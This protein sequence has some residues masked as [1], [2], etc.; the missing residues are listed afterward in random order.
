MLDRIDMFNQLCVVSKREAPVRVIQLSAYL[1]RQKKLFL[2]V[3]RGFL[4]T[5]KFDTMD[6]ITQIH[7]I[8]L[9]GSL[10]KSVKV[11]IQS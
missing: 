6:N 7:Q 10:Q 2:C 1:F 4:Q 8:P 3:I 11:G 9:Q 5:K